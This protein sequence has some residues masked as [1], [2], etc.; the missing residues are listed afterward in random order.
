MF[1]LLRQYLPTSDISYLLSAFLLLR[2]ESDLAISD[3]TTANEV[4]T[5]F[6]L[7][8]NLSEIF[9]NHSDSE[10]VQRSKKKN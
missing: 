1:V 7:L 6:H 4:G 5:L 9:A 2:G 8:E 10:Q 3:N